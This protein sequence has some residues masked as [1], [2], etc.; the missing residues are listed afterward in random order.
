MKSLIIACFIFISSN[1]V[2]SQNIE[3]L[4]ESLNSE[5]LDENISAMYIIIDQKIKET[6]PTIISLYEAKSPVIQILFLKALYIFEYE[7]IHDLTINFIQ[8]IDSVPIEELN[9]DPLEAKVEA[10]AILFSLDDY[11]TY[12]YIFEL[13]NRDGISNLQP[14]P[15]HLL[16]QIMNNVPGEELNA[17]QIFL[18]IW[19]ESLD[20]SFR[21]YSMF[22]LAEKYGS[23][24]NDKLI[25]SFINDTDVPVRDQA[26]SYLITFNYNGIQSVLRTR[27]TLDNDHTMRI[28]IAD[29]LLNHF[30]EPTDLKAVI[31][32][33]PNEP[34]ETARSLMGY[35]ID[36]FIPPKPA[37]LN[38]SGMI[39]RLVSYTTEMF[40]YGW[41]ADAKTRDYYITTLNQL[42]SQLE[43]RLYTEACATLN[44]KLLA[45][46]ETDR[47]AN[48]ITTEGYKF[49]HYYCEYIK[50]DFSNTL[51]PCE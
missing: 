30:G 11:S 26:L 12:N 3:D 45:R 47:T 40:T 25:D 48:N 14:A 33:Q 20:E 41:I 44:V 37:S 31:D 46:I 8:N 2:F 15:F 10:T 18:T 9:V 34:D 6:M 27:L 43:R 35:A 29:T 32:Y 16:N 17:K 50:E 13:I 49:L 23:A 28:A 5:R 21:Y 24:I 38:W 19:D 39:T 42:N 22:Y 51:Y 7:D 4:I 1:L 36:D